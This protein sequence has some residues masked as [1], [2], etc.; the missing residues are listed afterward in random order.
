MHP[1]STSFLSTAWKGEI[2]GP[3]G[4]V[5]EI[6]VLWSLPLSCSWSWVPG[7]LP[8]GKAGPGLAWWTGEEE[9]V[10]PGLMLQEERAR[11]PGPLCVG[12]WVEQ[13]QLGPRNKMR[14]L[15]ARAAAPCALG[16]W[17]CAEPSLVCRQPSSCSQGVLSVCHFV[18]KFPLFARTRSCC[19]CAQPNDLISTWKRPCLQRRSHSDVLGLGLQHMN[20]GGTVQPVTLPFFCLFVS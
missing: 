5:A 18:S 14:N 12:R 9:G 6:R 3:S 8:M 17:R 7:P 20:L 11:A 1:F 10:S 13:V 2:N 15:K 4:P 19:D 16:G